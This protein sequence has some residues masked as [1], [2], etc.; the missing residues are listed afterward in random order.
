MKSAIKPMVIKINKIRAVV[1]SGSRS[2]N[3][4]EKAGENLLEV[5]E[6]SSILIRC[7]FMYVPKLYS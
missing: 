1:A 3:W 5:M 2:Q 4:L 7:E 6:L